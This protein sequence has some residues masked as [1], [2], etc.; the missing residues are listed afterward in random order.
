MKTQLEKVYLLNVL[1]YIDSLESVKKFITIN[2]KCQEVSTSLRLYTKRRRSDYD[3]EH[4]RII[5]YNLFTIFPKTEI[6]HCDEKDLIQH[7]DLLKEKGIKQIHLHVHKEKEENWRISKKQTEIKVDKKIPETIRKKIVKMKYERTSY[8]NT[9]PFNDL[10]PNCKNLITNFRAGS[11]MITKSKQ[12]TLDKLT[13][14]VNKDDFGLTKF[15][16]QNIKEKEIVFKYSKV[17]CEK[18]TNI[19]N[20]GSIQ[21]FKQLGFDSIHHF[22]IDRLEPI[23]YDYNTK[24]IDLMEW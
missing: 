2:K 20:K 19:I 22:V 24:E 13:I 15:C 10:F 16:D 8:K 5:P 23:Y 17:I 7:S 1:L 11:G 9:T 3:F 4:E 21:Y 12:L 18:D 6:I 14:V